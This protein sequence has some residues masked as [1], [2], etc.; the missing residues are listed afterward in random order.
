MRIGETTAGATTRGVRRTEFPIIYIENYRR[1]EEID[2]NELS[3]SNAQLQQAAAENLVRTRL[4][5]DEFLILCRK[6]KPLDTLGWHVTS[7]QS[8]K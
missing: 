1:K 6:Y 8:W 4:M 7:A 5:S 3:K 2:M